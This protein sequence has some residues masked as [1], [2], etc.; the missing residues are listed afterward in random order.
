[1]PNEPSILPQRLK[2]ARDKTGFTQ[3]YVA[4]QLNIEIGTLSGYELGRR[5]PNTDMLAKLATIYNVPSD[6]LLG[7][8][9]D[10]GINSKEQL[11]EQFKKLPLNEKKNWLVQFITLIKDE[12]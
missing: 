11:L 1:M 7:L 12:K 6:Y 8:T 4:K 2:L 9:D 10:P 5:R 3:E